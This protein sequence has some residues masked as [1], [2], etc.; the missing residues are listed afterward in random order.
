MKQYLQTIS[1]E[2]QFINIQDISKLIVKNYITD[3]KQYFRDKGI[4]YYGDI[5]DNI[6]IRYTIQIGKIHYTFI[7]R[8]EYRFDRNSDILNYWF[9][10]YDMDKEKQHYQELKDIKNKELENK[11]RDLLYNNSIDEI[12]EKVKHKIFPL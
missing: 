12:F 1:D 6:Y 3:I 7:E 10:V 2:R 5:V 4:V 11:W 8:Q 9:E